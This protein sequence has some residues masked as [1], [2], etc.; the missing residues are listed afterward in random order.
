MATIRK[1][2]DFQW[3]AQIRRKGHSN[4]SHTFELKADAEDWAREIE[5]DMRRGLYIDRRESESTTLLEVLKNMRKRLLP[6]KKAKSVNYP[7]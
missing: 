2:G 1:R 6:T 3:E 7:E 5:R 4:Q